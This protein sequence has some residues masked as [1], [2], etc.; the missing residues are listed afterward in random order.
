MK[1]FREYLKEESVTMAYHGSPYDFTEFQTNE[2]F[3][4]KNKNEALRYGKKI[5]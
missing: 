3:L 5:I 2:V 4:A 1:T